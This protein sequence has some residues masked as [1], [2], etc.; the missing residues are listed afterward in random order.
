[1][2]G[3]EKRRKPSMT[4]LTTRPFERN[5]RMARLGFG[6]GAKIAAHSFS[7][8]FR[9]AGGRADA[10]RIFYAREAQVLADELGQLKGSIMKAGQML[11]LYGQY[12]LPPEAVDVLSSLQDDTPAVA[13][14]VVA[15]VLERS[16]GRQ[17]LAELEVD[18]RPLAAASLGQAHRAR[19]RSDGA[20]L[21]LKIQ[22]PGVG[23]AIESDVKT[24]SRVI[25]MTR[26]APRGLD[27][28]S[29]F[30]E[31]REMLHREVDYVAERRFTEDFGER[32]ADDERYVVPRIYGEFCSDQVLATSF[33]AGEGARAKAVQ[34]LPQS[35]RN[36]LALNFLDLFLIEF[37]DWG[38][39]QT[40][41]HFGN[42]RI[43]QEAGR[44]RIVLLDFGAT[45]VF[46]R[47]FVDGYRN[48]VAG[49]LARDA[50]RVIDG[51]R[52]IG[53]MDDA[54][55][56]NVVSAFVDLCELI[57]EPFREP[58]DAGEGQQWFNAQ[59]AYRWAESDLLKRVTTRASR[60]ALSRYFRV[61][62]REI[63]FL[64]RRLAG[65]FIMVATLGAEVSARE[66]LL[67]RL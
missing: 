36:E 30:A 35:V 24:L 40:D 41:P 39:V 17:R 59:G 54:F 53:L 21:V 65:A 66:R 37:F 6:T 1:M 42:Y 51:A 26:L 55:P 45:R 34:S 29:V 43:R 12:F 2:D 61:P 5:L 9:D 14:P 44:P 7:N 62:P 63:V 57:V 38:M 27:L 10:D 46:G 48:I 31:V 52:A 60:N 3:D 28:N 25:G 15:P 47:G 23:D 8:L 67:A 22:Y 18:E 49:A 56:Q 16:L 50:A 19:R 32:L 20:E 11:S 64:H 33:E 58:H 4:K 13:W